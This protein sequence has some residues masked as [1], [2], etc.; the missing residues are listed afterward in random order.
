MDDDDD[1]GGDGALF[2]QLL[3]RSPLEY[4]DWQHQQARWRCLKNI[5]LNNTERRALLKFREFR[6]A[7]GKQRSPKL[8]SRKA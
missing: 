1:D 2:E 7:N 8:W 4:T 6:R 5:A 3:I